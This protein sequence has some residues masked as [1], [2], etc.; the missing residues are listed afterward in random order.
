MEEYKY[1]SRAMGTDVLI[2]VV[3]NKEKD[4]NDL[5]GAALVMVES[6]EQQFSRFLPES[7]LSQLNAIG[8]LRV[9][10][11]FLSVLKTALKLSRKT[12][13]VFNPLFQIKRFGYDTDYADISSHSTVSEPYNTD[14]SA[15]T[16]DET[17]H[18]ISLAEGQQLDF[19]GFLKG[20]VAK[21]IVGTLT[22]SELPHQGIIVNLGGDLCTTGSDA[23]NEPFV[24]EIRNP[25]LGTHEAIVVEN[26]CVATSGTY[27]RQWKHEGVSYHH[28]LDSSGGKNPETAVISATVVH[29]DGA[30]AEGYATTLL[31]EPLDRALACIG[32]P[33]LTY[34]LIKEDGAVVTS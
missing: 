25:V 24:F 7:E 1:Q 16:L 23:M 14:I 6:Y 29:E 27:K 21:E 17:T 28:V 33:D 26:Q 2:S 31:S 5:A 13:G 34:T 18:T 30:C 4:A 20:Y 12:H 8:T 19:G 15:I 3:A 9:S 10:K 11:R 32:E 22:R